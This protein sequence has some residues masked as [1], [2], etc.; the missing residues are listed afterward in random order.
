MEAPVATADEARRGVT[1]VD[2]PTCAAAGGGKKPHGAERAPVSLA[3]GGAA[4][5]AARA[6]EGNGDAGNAAPAAPN[7]SAADVNAVVAWPS[8][9]AA[10]VSLAVTIAAQRAWPERARVRARR[11]P[12]AVHSRAPRVCY[13]A[14][15][16][17]GC[18]VVHGVSCCVGPLL[19]RR[20]RAR[21]RSAIAAL[22]A[23]AGEPGAGADA[24]SRGARARR[25]R[26]LRSLVPRC[27][28]SHR[29]PR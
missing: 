23:H 14:A 3:A 18:S 11:T 22:A 25:R 1:D 2:A 6:S 21:M 10:I 12:D 17:E 4:R 7:K 28:N 15:R 27:G 24:R 26:T 19:T 9:V 5:A 29:N 13:C 20:A 16:V 8:L